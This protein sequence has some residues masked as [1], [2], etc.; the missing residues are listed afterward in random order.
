[1]NTNIRAKKDDEYQAL[2]YFLD[3]YKAA[4]G[5]VIEVISVSER[6]DFICERPGGIRVGVELAKIR[7]Q[8]PEIVLWEQILDRRDFMTSDGAIAKIQN[9]LL[10]KEAK[11]REPSWQLPENTLLLLQLTD[12]PLSEIFRRLN[13]MLFPDLQD[14]GFAQVWLADYTGLEAY[15][16]IELYCLYPF[17][18]WGYYQRAIKKPFG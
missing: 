1:M 5:E 3:A 18:L 2:E 11:R 12:I 15:G 8:D 9:M 6:P 10:Q 16:D 7:R 14:S 13:P 4:C 17:Q